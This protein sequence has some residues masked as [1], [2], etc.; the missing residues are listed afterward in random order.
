L[1]LTLVG[2]LPWGTACYWA[3]IE[4][5]AYNAAYGQEAGREE[6]RKEDAA[7]AD[8]GRSDVV[9]KAEPHGGAGGQN[10]G[11]QKAAAGN[12]PKDEWD[13]V[14][15]FM[16]EN[17]PNRHQL[18]LRQNPGPNAPARVRLLQRWRTLQQLQQS[19]ETDLYDLSTAQFREEDVVVGL[20]AQ[21]RQAR[22]RGNMPRMNQLRQDIGAEAAKLVDLGLQER[23]LRIQHAET[24]LQAQKD[25]LEQDKANEQELVQQ[26]TE[27]IMTN[28]TQ[29]GRGAA[30]PVDVP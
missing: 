27:Q 4:S 16:R 2:G 17:S 13:Q 21:Y 25:K 1:L 9:P 6:Q 29:G 5:P 8:A 26:R 24:L 28:Q 15:A 12:A 3:A 23:A 14:M 30:P 22:N 20:S 11:G 7:K 10:G 19:G 18:L